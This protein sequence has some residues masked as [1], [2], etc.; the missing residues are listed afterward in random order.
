[1][2]LRPMSFS[3]LYF[4]GWSQIA[5]CNVSQCIDGPQSQWSCVFHTY[6]Q[7]HNAGSLSENATTFD[8]SKN[9]TEFDF[10]IGTTS[11]GSPI[12]PWGDWFWYVDYV[13]VARLCVWICWL[14]VLMFD[15][16]HGMFQEEI[17]SS[18][19]LGYVYDSQTQQFACKKHFLSGCSFAL[20]EGN[21]VTW[22]VNK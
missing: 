15:R 14:G 18:G 12:P 6:K 19:K 5:D 11:D 17:T 4:T 22:A 8:S 10:L 2:N 9:P 7:E 1:V 16:L 13:T 3:S 20:G 21:L